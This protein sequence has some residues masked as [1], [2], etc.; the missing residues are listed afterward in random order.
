MS[1]LRGAL[2]P[3]RRSFFHFVMDDKLVKYEWERNEENIQQKIV[4]GEVNSRNVPP[5]FSCVVVNI[6][7]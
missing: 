7:Q 1:I 5:L 4:E 6:I 2:H 3:C